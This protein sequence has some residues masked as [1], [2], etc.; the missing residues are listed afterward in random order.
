MDISLLPF[1]AIINKTARYK[2][3]HV[4][5]FFFISLKHLV[6][7][8]LEIKQGYIKLYKKLPNCIHQ[9]DCTILHTQQWWVE[10]HQKYQVLTKLPHIFAKNWHWQAL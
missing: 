7:R 2:W 6:K 8:F 4:D 1:G 5:I 10:L 3:E 9:S